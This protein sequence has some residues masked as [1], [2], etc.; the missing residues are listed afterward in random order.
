MQG[1]AHGHM[2]LYPDLEDLVSNQ[3]TE[4]DQQCKGAS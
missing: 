2:G 1:L 3:N 4:D